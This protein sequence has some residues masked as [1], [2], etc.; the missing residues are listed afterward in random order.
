MSFT[1]LEVDGY[2]VRGVPEDLCVG[3]ENTWFHLYLAKYKANSA[4]SRDLIIFWDG[5]PREPGSVHHRGRL[6]PGLLQQAQ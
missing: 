2:F 5:A 1:P 6:E 4:V 3:L